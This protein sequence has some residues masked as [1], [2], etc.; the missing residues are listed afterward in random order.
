MINKDV[1]PILQPLTFVQIF[2]PRVNVPVFDPKGPF[3]M[4]IV[5]LPPMVCAPDK[6]KEFVVMDERKT[7]ALFSVKPSRDSRDAAL[8]PSVMS[9]VTVVPSKIT[10]P[11]EPPI[12]TIDPAEEVRLP[13]FTRALG[14]NPTGPSGVTP[15]SKVSPAL[16][17]VPTK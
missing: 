11:E 14:P 7:F 5:P 3:A 10:G 12:T 2:G 16:L 15:R 9:V 1:P 6:T 8:F 4:L 13:P 17:R